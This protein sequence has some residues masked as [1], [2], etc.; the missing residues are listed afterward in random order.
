ML[1]DTFAGA[2]SKL[3]TDVVGD[4]VLFRP[5]GFQVSKTKIL[6]FCL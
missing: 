4:F 3:G 2:Q 6:H 1:H 5:L